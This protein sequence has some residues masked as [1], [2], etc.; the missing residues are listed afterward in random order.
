MPGDDDPPNLIDLD[1]LEAIEEMED[2]DPELL[3]TIEVLR[4]RI[5]EW[6]A[7]HLE[8]CPSDEEECRFHYKRIVFTDESE[9]YVVICMNCG[10]GESVALAERTPHGTEWSILRSES[11]N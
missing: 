6:Q 9:E 5:E 7:V 4:H 11:L 10:E 1:E 2:A 3:E 8:F